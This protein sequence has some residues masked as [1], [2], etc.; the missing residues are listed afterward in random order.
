[1]CYK[2]IDDKH[3]NS[4]PE[5]NKTGK[6]ISNETVYDDIYHKIY[7]VGKGY[8]LMYLQFWDKCSIMQHNSLFD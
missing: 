5:C 2:K 6:N 1:M 4:C 7:I 3:Y 8:I